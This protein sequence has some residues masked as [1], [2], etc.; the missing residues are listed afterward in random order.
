TS[1]LTEKLAGRIRREGP[2]NFRDFME[3]ALYDPE[4]GYYARRAAIGEGGDFVTSPS[5]SPLFARAIA[6]LFVRDATT[7]PEAAV[8]CEA[9]ARNGTFL[10]DFR[11]ALSD[12]HAGIAAR[13]ELWAIERSAAGR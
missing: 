4:Y 12:L 7:I 2:V 5:I 3:A 13:T 11:A 8:F 1:S 6:R 10:R 9:G